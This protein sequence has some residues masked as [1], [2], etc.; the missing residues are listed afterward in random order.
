MWGLKSF[1]GGVSADFRDGFAIGVF[2]TLVLGYSA[3]KLGYKE[4]RY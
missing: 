2:V 3:E 1:L 4:P